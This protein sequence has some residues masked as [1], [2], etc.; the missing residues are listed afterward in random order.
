M[1]IDGFVDGLIKE[2]Q[3]QVAF[4]QEQNKYDQIIFLCA[5]VFL[6]VLIG[7]AITLISM[8]PCLR[9]H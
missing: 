8:S 4:E 2:R 9:G 7:I 6:G 3:H 5:G 1:K